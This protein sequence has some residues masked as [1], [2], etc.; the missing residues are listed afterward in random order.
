MSSNTLIGL[1]L[2]AGGLVF[3]VSGTLVLTNSLVDPQS[4]EGF[5]SVEVEDAEM[6]TPPSVVGEAVS[7]HVVEQVTPIPRSKVSAIVPEVSRPRTPIPE[8]TPSPVSP[9]SIDAGA[10]LSSEEKGYLFEQ[11]VV[12]R[13]NRRYFTIKEW[14]GDKYA[15]GIYAESSTYPDLEIEFGLRD[16]RVVFAVECKWRKRYDSDERPGIEW[17][18]ERQIEN[19]QR[20]Q[21]ERGIPVFVVIGMGGEPDAPNDLFVANLDQ[22]RYPFASAKYLAS[23]RRS[24]VETDFYFDDDR[25]ELR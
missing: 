2:I 1:L 13:F 18:T 25:G 11:W 15:D 20:F 23:L 10:I 21:R 12:K 17:A 9:G 3:V 16:T 22:L 24:R 5:E 19:Y 14:R 4:E 7:P 6:G 8:T